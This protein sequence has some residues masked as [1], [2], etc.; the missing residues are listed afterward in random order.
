MSNSKQGDKYDLWMMDPKNGDEKQ[1]FAKKNKKIYCN[2]GNRL[3]DGRLYTL[4][5]DTDGTFRCGP[6]RDLPTEA[7]E[8]VSTK[9]SQCFSLLWKSD[10]NLNI[11]GLFKTSCYFMCLRKGFSHRAVDLH[12]WPFLDF[13]R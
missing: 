10:K 3:S 13:T 9:V 5:Y 7:L 1:T 6:Y 12:R 4:Q 8:F 11:T 2:G